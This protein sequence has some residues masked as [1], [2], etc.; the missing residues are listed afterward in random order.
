VILGARLTRSLIHRT[1]SITIS[2]P[3]RMSIPPLTTVI[4]LNVPDGWLFGVDLQFFQ[5]TPQFRGVKAI[6]NGVHV[7]HWGVDQQN[8]RS[9][10][11][12]V[13]EDQNVVILRWNKEKE[14]ME[15]GDEIGELDISAIKSR[16]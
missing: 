11:F 13:A 8:V 16:E 4:C 3:R 15:I 5:T 12:F 14:E 6:P 10:H 2:D 1:A 9:G 7:V